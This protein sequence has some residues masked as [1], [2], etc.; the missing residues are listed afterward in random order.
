M[1]LN[2]PPAEVQ[3]KPHPSRLGGLIGVKNVVR[4]LRRHS[5]AIVLDLDCDASRVARD[6]DDHAP[7]RVRPLGSGVDR[8]ADEIDQNLLD[9]DPVRVDRGDRPTL[10]TST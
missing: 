6:P 5:P 4:Q 2:D 9:L 1:P 7:A 10:S 3:S 8:I